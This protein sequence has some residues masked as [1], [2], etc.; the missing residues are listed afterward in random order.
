MDVSDR[1]QPSIPVANG[2]LQIVVVGSCASGKS[3]LV[4]AL[5]SCGFDA[6]ACAQEHSA[7]PD[8]WRHQKPDL[9]V[10]LEADLAAVRRRRSPTWPETIYWAQRQRLVNARQAADVIIDTSKVDVESTVR[11]V[12]REARQRVFELGVDA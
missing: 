8:L 4:K 5:R 7:V 6:F 2:S 1:K 3:T 11:L 10:F 12:L 9:V